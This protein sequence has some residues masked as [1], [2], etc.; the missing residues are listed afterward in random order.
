MNCLIVTSLISGALVKKKNNLQ[1]VI[2][3]LRLFDFG[4]HRKSHIGNKK[5]NLRLTILD[6][7]LTI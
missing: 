7:Q 5:N 6:L 3:D 4:K 1:L 2:I